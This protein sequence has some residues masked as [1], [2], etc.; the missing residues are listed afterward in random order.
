MNQNLKKFFND[1][2]WRICEDLLKGYIHDLEDATTIDTTQTAETVKAEI[3][4]RQI[5]RDRL[6]SFLIETGFIKE[7]IKNDSISFE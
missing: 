2:D 7:D 6:K 4:G 5:A 1:P 3:I